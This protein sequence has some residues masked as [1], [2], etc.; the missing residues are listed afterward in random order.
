MSIACG[1]FIGIG[2][3]AEN[4]GQS[5]LG[6]HLAGAGAVY[7]ILGIGLNILAKI[8]TKNNP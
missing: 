6:W 2:L 3:L 1:T 5:V 8:K 7:L 4:D